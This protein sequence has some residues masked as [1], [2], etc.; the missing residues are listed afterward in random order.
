ML[1]DLAQVLNSREI[2]AGSPVYPFA[3]LL[4]FLKRYFAVGS[5]VFKKR[6]KLNRRAFFELLSR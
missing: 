4:R 5:N 2:Q 1:K 6:D 3:E